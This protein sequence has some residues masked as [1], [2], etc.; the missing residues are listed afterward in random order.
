MTSSIVADMKQTHGTNFTLVVAEI[1][2]RDVLF[3]CTKR[4]CDSLNCRTD[5]NAPQLDV[6]CIDPTQSNIQ[7]A[8]KCV[9]PGT[10]VVA[11]IEAVSGADTALTL[12]KTINA[13]GAKFAFAEQSV[14]SPQSV[15]PAGQILSF[16]HYGT[17][18][19]SM[20]HDFIA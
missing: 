3:S 2:G 13:A 14:G 5:I 20:T 12:S 15:F 8:I 1:A 7:A 11:G 17:I 9:S 19:I 4:A 10:I 16:V 18:A 6:I